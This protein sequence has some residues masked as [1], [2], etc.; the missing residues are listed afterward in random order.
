[1]WH[2]LRGVTRPGGVPDLLFPD[3]PFDRFRWQTVYR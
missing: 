1:M 2:P 3:V